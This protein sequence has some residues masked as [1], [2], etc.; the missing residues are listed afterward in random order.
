VDDLQPPRQRTAAALDTIERLTMG[1]LMVMSAVVIVLT[2]V[3]L[4]W[5]IVT[6]VFSPPLGLVAADQLLD[7]FGLLMLV[8]IGV[9]LLE[10]MRVYVRQHEVR[11]EVI[12]LVAVIALARKMITIDLK[13]TPSVSLVG[14]AAMLLALGAAYWLIRRTR[15]RPI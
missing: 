8:L 7:L 10:S 1:L 15:Q 14:V 11:A 9:E 3:R 2:V 12:L 5:M 6:T 4:G 13:S